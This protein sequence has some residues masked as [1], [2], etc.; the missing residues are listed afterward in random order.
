MELAP[1]KDLV[2]YEIYPNSFKDANGD[3]FGDL[4]GI[5]SKLDYIK[6]LGFNAIWLNPIYE[7]PF[8]DGGYDI[9]DEWHVA[10]RFG[11]NDDL[12]ELVKDC[13][14]K[15]IRLFLDLVPGHM[16]AENPEFIKSGEATPNEFSDVFIWNS[17]VWECENGYRL[18]SGMLPR[19]GCYMV[20]FF[21]HQPAINYGFNKIEYPSWQKSYKETEAGK[22]YLE[23]IMK[24]WLGFDIDGFRVDMADSLVKNDD[25]KE[26]TIELWNTIRQDLKDQGVKEYYL[27]SEWSYPERALKAGFDSDFVLDHWTNFS[28]YLFRE[29]EMGTKAPLLVKYDEELFKM[30]QSDVKRRVNAAKREDKAI[31]VISGN[32]DTWRLASFLTG[33]SLKLAYLFILTMP[34]VPYI[35]Y[36]DELGFHTDKSLTSFEG[37]YQRTGSRLPMKFDSSNNNGFSTAEKT[38]LPIYQADKTV[39]EEQADPDSLMNLIAKLIKIRSEQTDLRSQDFEFMNAKR[40]AYRRGKIAVYINIKEEEMKAEIGKGKVLLTIGQCQTEGHQLVIPCHAGAI[41][42]E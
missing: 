3:G 35:Y 40:F 5:I 8:K 41:V 7:S 20:N 18:I 31:S 19:F 24:Y 36:G 30:F 16:S 13:H 27:T 1:F 42:E 15:G 17:S 2:F 22:K 25:T 12:K 23:K 26:A 11:T 33:D 10:K 6:G 28:H 32:H 34:G 4:K 38:F 14:E 39:E 37:G 21:A 29:D 9:S